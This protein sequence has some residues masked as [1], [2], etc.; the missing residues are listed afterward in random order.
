MKNVKR[1]ASESHKV[2]KWAIRSV[3]GAYACR[4]PEAKLP[5]RRED[6][7]F[8]NYDDDRALGFAWFLLD[9]KAQAEW[10]I[11]HLEGVSPLAELHPV[12]IDLTIRVRI[13]PEGRR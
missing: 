1:P 5:F 11:K 7:E 9:S 6:L 8:W 12:R 4:K 13:T 2:T 10:Y 3:T